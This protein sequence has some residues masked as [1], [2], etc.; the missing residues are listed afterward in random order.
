MRSVDSFQFRDDW[1][2]SDAKTGKFSPNRVEN[3]PMHSNRFQIGKNCP[4]GVQCSPPQ[5]PPF[6]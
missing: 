4:R 5:I 2:E 3:A 1:K 6:R